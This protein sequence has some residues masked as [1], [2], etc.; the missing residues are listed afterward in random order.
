MPKKLP[1]KP[2]LVWQE[3]L[4]VIGDMGDEI[5]SRKVADHFGITKNDASMRIKYL[6]NWNFIK[7]TGVVNHG[8]RIYKLT[9]YGRK[10]INQ[11]EGRGKLNRE[12]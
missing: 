10:T 5:T 2:K 12:S 11:L 1:T 4:V 3:I 8:L 7:R 9:N 6:K